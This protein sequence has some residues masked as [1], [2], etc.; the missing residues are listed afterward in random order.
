MHLLFGNLVDPVDL[1]DFTWK[2]QALILRSS[3]VQKLRFQCVFFYHYSVVSCVTDTLHFIDRSRLGI[4]II[5]EIYSR[6]EN[7]HRFDNI[8]SNDIFNLD[9]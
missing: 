1:D 4:F 6:T 2:M 8:A 3:S 9:V 7:C 5:N